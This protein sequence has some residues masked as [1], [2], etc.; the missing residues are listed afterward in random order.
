[1]IPGTGLFW[2][3]RTVAAIGAPVVSVTRPVRVSGTVRSSMKFRGVIGTPSLTVTLF[4]V[5]TKP[6]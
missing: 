6:S 5:G 1:M 2:V 3:N 4:A